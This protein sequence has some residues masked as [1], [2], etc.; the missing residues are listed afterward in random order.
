MEPIEIYAQ[1]QSLVKKEI[2]DE[3]ATYAN[4]ARYNVVPIPAHSHNGIDST[5]IDYEDVSGI[6]VTSVIPTYRPENGTMV[7]YESG[8]TRRIYV[9]INGSWRYVNLT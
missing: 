9:F 4:N 5:V 8:T 3:I 6:P 7:L 1:I 2:K